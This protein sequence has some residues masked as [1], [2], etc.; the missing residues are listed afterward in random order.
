MPTSGASERAPSEWDF[1][2][3]RLSER[4]HQDVHERSDDEA[5][6]YA[7]DDRYSRDDGF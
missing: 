4:D 7:G 2:G 5:E 1:S 6:R 3:V